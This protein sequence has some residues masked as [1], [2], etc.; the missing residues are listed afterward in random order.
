VLGTDPRHIASGRIIPSE[1]YA[2][3]SY[4]VKADDGA[5]VCV[6]TTGNGVEGAPGQHGISLRSTDQGRTWEKPVD[7]EPA[8][9]PEASYAVLF[10]VP[11][12]R[13]YAFCNHNT[14]H[15][16]EVRREDKGVYQCVDSLEHY[17]FKY[18]DDHS[19]SWS[20]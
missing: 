3:Q 16:T 1:G 7:I 2:D 9:G 18:S 12:G 19:R 4:V 5:W 17:V 10:K 8:D 20:N 11:S 14:D 15:V 6:M 13:I